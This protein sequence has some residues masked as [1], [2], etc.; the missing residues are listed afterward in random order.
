MQI[1]NIVTGETLPRPHDWRGLYRRRLRIAAIE[2]LI[3]F[4]VD[5]VSSG[6][7]GG[8][9]NFHPIQSAEAVIECG[10]HAIQS[11]EA[12]IAVTKLFKKPLQVAAHFVQRL[13]DQFVLAFMWNLPGS[14]HSDSPKASRWP[15]V[16]ALWNGSVSRIVQVYLS[17]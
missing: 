7:D 9:C 14:R 15:V 3:E 2:N 11:A 16:Q 17:L 1:V 13:L 8:E 5:A 10:F 4:G 6:Q 12:V